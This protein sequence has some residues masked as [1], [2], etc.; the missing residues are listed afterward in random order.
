MES[1]GAAGYGRIVAQTNR[2][3]PTGD[4]VAAFVESI[5]DDTRRAEARLLIEVTQDVTGRGPARSRVSLEVR[6]AR[7]ASAAGFRPP[8]PARRR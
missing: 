4:D 5:A 1:S 3:V 8:R 2:T 6:P 7:N